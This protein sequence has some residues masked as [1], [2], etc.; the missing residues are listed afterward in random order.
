MRCMHVSEDFSREHLN[1]IKW[2]PD[3]FY[4]DLPYWNWVGYLSSKPVFSMIMEGDNSVDKVSQLTSK[5]E[6][7][8]WYSKRATVYANKS[9]EQGAAGCCFVVPCP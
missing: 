4:Q 9:G 2:N 3:A 1:N 6:R 7:P 5:K 8:F